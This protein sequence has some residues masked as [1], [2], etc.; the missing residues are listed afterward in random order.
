MRLAA[1]SMWFNPRQPQWQSMY[2]LLSSFI[3]WRAMRL[4]YALG[5]VA[6]CLLAQYSG[7]FFKAGSS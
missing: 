3:T 7:V 1:G 6:G 4:V 5:P 2:G